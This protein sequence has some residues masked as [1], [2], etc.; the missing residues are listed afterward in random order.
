MSMTILKWLMTFTD[1]RSHPQLL[2][3]EEVEVVVVVFQLERHL[4]AEVFHQDLE[5]LDLALV[6][7]AF[8]HLHHLGQDPRLLPH[9]LRLHLIGW[10]HLLIPDLCLT[11][12]AWFVARHHVLHQLL[13]LM[14]FW[15]QMTIP[16]LVMITDETQ[17]MHRHQLSAV[18]I[19]V[20][21]RSLEAAAVHQPEIAPLGEEILVDRSPLQGYRHAAQ[22]ARDGQIL[23]MMPLV[24]QRHLFRGVGVGIMF[25]FQPNIPHS[26]RL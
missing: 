21:N 2:G 19:Q 7:A 9:A 1:R 18:M 23:L 11:H 3:G 6:E 16:R 13:T 20:A 8:R 17:I 15:D 5:D 10:D 25:L 12:Q 4:A 22:A 14:I 26:T 24:D